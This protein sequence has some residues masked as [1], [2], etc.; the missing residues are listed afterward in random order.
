[1]RSALPAAIRATPCLLAALTLCLSAHAQVADSRIVQVKVYPGSAT[2]ERVARVAA[3]SRSLTFACLPAGLDVQSL[4]V[5]AD[6]AVRVGETSVQTQ[7]R[8]L[9]PR[10]SRASSGS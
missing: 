4:Q 10:K 3:G 2:V 9:S 6:G 5:V 1:M 7:P 8:A